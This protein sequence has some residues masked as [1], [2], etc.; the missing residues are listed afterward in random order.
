[1]IEETFTSG[2][3]M[4]LEE[5]MR[6]EEKIIGGGKCQIDGGKKKKINK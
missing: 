2:G 6:V 5:N 1:M 4:Q 3:K